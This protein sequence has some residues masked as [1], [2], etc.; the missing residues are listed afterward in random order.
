M[1]I[2]PEKEIEYYDWVGIGYIVEDTETGDGSYMIGG[3]LRGGATAKKQSKTLQWIKIFSE[4]V[5]NG[6]GPNPI[7]VIC[8]DPTTMKSTIN[9]LN[10]NTQL[11]LLYR[12]ELGYSDKENHCFKQPRW[13]DGQLRSYQDIE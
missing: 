2:I 9:M 1:V 13:K 4:E 10:R 8:T 7:P 5:I 3:G 6:L 12:D 11:Y